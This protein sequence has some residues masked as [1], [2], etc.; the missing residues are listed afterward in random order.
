MPRSLLYGVE[1]CC[2]SLAV[3]TCCFSAERLA[4][5]VLL[6]WKML[7]GLRIPSAVSIGGSTAGVLMSVNIACLLLS[8]AIAARSGGLL[9]D[10]GLLVSLLCVQGVLSAVLMECLSG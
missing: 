5:G 2:A 7:G 4:H 6:D 8:V 10:V 9:K 3:A 1:T